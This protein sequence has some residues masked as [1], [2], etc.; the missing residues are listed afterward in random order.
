MN[1]QLFFLQKYDYFHYKSFFFTIIFFLAAQHLLPNE[2]WIKP[3]ERQ[4]FTFDH[5]FG[6]LFTVQWYLWFF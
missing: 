5:L 6:C 3:M 1:I 4:L 2:Q